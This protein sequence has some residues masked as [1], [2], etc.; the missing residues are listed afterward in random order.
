MYFGGCTDRSDFHYKN[1]KLISPYNLLSVLNEYL[2]A[3]GLS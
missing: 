2:K 1:G 3:I